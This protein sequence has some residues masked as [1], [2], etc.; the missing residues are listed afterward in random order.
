MCG[1]VPPTVVT[2]GVC[3][4][5][6]GT[7][8]KLVQIIGLAMDINPRLPL[9]NFRDIRTMLGLKRFHRPKYQKSFSTKN[10]DAL[11]DTCII[12]KSSYTMSNYETVIL[13]KGLNFIFTDNKRDYTTENLE[14]VEK[15]EPNLQ[16]KI[17][18]EEGKLTI[19]LNQIKIIQINR[20]TRLRT[21]L[22]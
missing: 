17:F 18:F 3:Q 11:K 6:I 20:N 22:R 16:I 10:V 1:C 15:F 13:S 12:N 7:P 9:G 5:N 4:D 19:L 14:L 8:S 2:S 21:Y